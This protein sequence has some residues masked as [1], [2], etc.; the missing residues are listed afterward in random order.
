MNKSCIV[1]PARIGSSRLPEKSI[2][3]I[4]GKTMIQRVIEQAKKSEIKDIIL[5]TDDERIAKIGNDLDIIVVMTPT[6]FP[7]G[8]DRS[9]YA[10]EKINH[11]YEYIIN[12]QG[13][14]PDIEP[15]LIN[16]MNYNLRKYE[17][18]EMLTIARKIDSIELK[19]NP[20]YVKI[21][22]ENIENENNFEKVYKALFFSRAAIPYGTSI[23]YK[24]IGIYG[25]KKN[26]L[27]K[28]VLLPQSNLEKIESLEQMRAI[29]NNI[30]IYAILTEKEPISIDTPEDL[31]FAI[32]NI[33]A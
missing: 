20:S 4:N 3:M 15:E 30:T 33:Y 5:A 22:L 25:Y 9:H 16:K 1:I 31:D 2:K 21:I 29:E 6:N 12:L 28:F 19:N 13:D 17:N 8:T 14:L 23:F 24:H 26:T 27:N 32:K 10:L 7:S 18:I 11:K